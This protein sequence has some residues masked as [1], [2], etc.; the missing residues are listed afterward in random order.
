M[1]P[2]VTNLKNWS[3]HLVLLDIKIAF[4][5]FV[6][7]IF[8]ACWLEADNFHLKKDRAAPAYSKS[9]FDPQAN[10]EKWKTLNSTKYLKH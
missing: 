6:G 10:V 1:K 9:K 5:V 3:R 8:F 4:V 2:H 7:C